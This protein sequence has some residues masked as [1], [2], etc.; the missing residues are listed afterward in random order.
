[1]GTHAHKQARCSRCSGQTVPLYTNCV[2]AQKTHV[3][4][5]VT[6]TAAVMSSA[7]AACLLPPR[8]LTALLT[9]L[10]AEDATLATTLSEFGKLF[11]KT[12][13]FRVG[14]WGR[15]ACGGVEGSGPSTML[16]L[17]AGSAL[18]L[19][20]E[21]DLL[22]RSQRIA[23]F[24]VL[25]DLYREV[26][27]LAGGRSGCVHVWC[28]CLLRMGSVLVLLRLCLRAGDGCMHTT[29]EAGCARMVWACVCVCVCVCVCMCV[30]V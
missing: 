19:L 5:H 8:E 4:A 21:D 29:C 11:A 22:T 23:A 15:R 25:S 12:E 7:G 6:V 3:T 26:C 1:M 16:R 14:A 20:L 30:C 27:R 18:C 17:P 9:M 13:H 24:Y 2:P 10:R 28:L